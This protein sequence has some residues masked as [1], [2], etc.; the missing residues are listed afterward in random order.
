M[1]ELL[2]TFEHQVNMQD[3]QLEAKSAETEP[4]LQ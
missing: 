1:R 4:T 3:K 2:A